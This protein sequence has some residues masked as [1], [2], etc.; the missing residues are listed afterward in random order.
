MDAAGYVDAAQS[1][2]HGHF[3]PS[4]TAVAAGSS[5]DHEPAKASLYVNHALSARYVPL[6][7]AAQC[8][9]ALSSFLGGNCCF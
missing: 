4:P 9:G 1:T 7:T 5:D 2:V 8:F 3:L 6:A